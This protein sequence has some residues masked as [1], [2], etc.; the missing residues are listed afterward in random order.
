MAQIKGTSIVTNTE[1]NISLNEFILIISEIIENA[2][3]QKLEYYSQHLNTSRL[4]HSINVAY[5]T[6]KMSKSLELDYI[7]ATKG[8]LLHD[9]FL[10]NWQDKNHNFTEH[11]Y[12]HPIAA[13]ENSKKYFEVN[14]IMEDCILNHMWPVTHTRPKTAEGHIVQLADKYSA[15]IEMSSQSYRFLKGKTLRLFAAI[16][17]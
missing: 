17:K 2:E 14:E 5:Y 12:M 7:S 10:Y 13:L 4:Q 9:F 16:T 11:K 6:Y 15:S 8:A 1:K 3:F